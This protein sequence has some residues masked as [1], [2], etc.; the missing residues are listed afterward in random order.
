MVTRA[1]LLWTALPNGR[2]AD[3][4]L[5]LSVHAAPRLTVSGGGETRLDHDAFADVL[6]WPPPGLRFSVTVVGAA[7]QT[8]YSGEDVVEIEP[9]RPAPAEELWQ[10]VFGPSTPVRS[11]AVP[12]LTTVTWHTYPA[13]KLAAW[14]AETYGSLAI[15][16][17]TQ[18][19]TIGALRARFD[20]IDFTGN[21]D[22]RLRWQGARNALD[23]VLSSQGVVD[24][25]APSGP[26]A[27][28]WQLEDFH[29]PAFRDAEDPEKAVEDAFAQGPALPDLDLHQ[30]LAFIGRHPS[31]MRWLG[32]VHDLE[33]P[34]PSGGATGVLLRVRPEWEPSVGTLV[35]HTPWTAC[36]LG[37]GWFTAQPLASETMRHGQL[38][39]DLPDR[40]RALRVDVAGSGLKATRAAGNLTRKV[41][42]PTADTPTT[43]T[44]PSLRTAGFAVV[45]QGRAR[46]LR[47]GAARAVALDGA[48]AAALT[49]GT[50]PT[51]HAEDLV[52]GY[53]VD[54][55]DVASRSWRSLMERQ[56]SF[57]FPDRPDLGE[58]PDTGEGM[59]SSVPTRK[60]DGPDIFAA[61]NLF[62][63]DGWSLVVDRPGMTLALEAPAGADPLQARPVNAAG[64]EHRVTSRFEVVPGT[65]PVLRF[66]HRYEL[67]A[68]TV[69]LAGNSVPMDTLPGI[70]H[71]TSPQHYGRHEPVASPTVLLRTATVPGESVDRVVLRSELAAGPT[72]PSNARHLVVP[73]LAQLQVEEHGALDVVG[74]QGRVPDGS[75]QRHEQIALRD[76][77][78]LSQV[79]EEQL[80]ADGSVL[81]PEAH[82]PVTWSPDPLSRGVALQFVSGRHR[83]TVLSE[84]LVAATKAWPGDWA[85]RL[86]VVDGEGAPSFSPADGGVIVV[87]LRKGDV[88]RIRV[89]SVI[90]DPADVERF[91]LWT[92][93]LGKNPPSATSAGLRTRIAAGLHWM[94]TPDHELVLVHAVRQPLATPEYLGSSPAP[95]R[96]LGATFAI[97]RGTFAFDRR[98]TGRIDVHAAWSEPVDEPAAADDP[99]PVDDTPDVLPPFSRNPDAV[100]FHLD[101]E[102]DDDLDEAEQD[103]IGR[104]EFGDTKHRRVT[105]TAVATTRFLEHFRETYTFVFDGAGSVVELSEVGLVAGTVTLHHAV[106][107]PPG[108]EEG[109]PPTLVP[110]EA[111]DV[112]IDAEEGRITFG[113]GTSGA[114]PTEGTPIEATFNVPPVTRTSSAEGAQ[115][116]V[117]PSSARPPTPGVLYALPT[118]AWERA[119]SGGPAATPAKITSKRGGQGLRIYLERPWWASGEGELL[120][121]V[122][123]PGAGGS[124]DLTDTDALNGYVTE[125]GLDPVFGSANLPR[126]YPG[127]VAFPQRKATGTQLSLAELGPQGDT[128]DVAGHEV[129][130]DTGRNLWY[131]DIEV[132]SGKAYTPMIRL[133]LAR[134]QPDSLQHAHLSSIVLA[135]VVQT[136]PDRL[137]TVAFAS[138][139][140]AGC[141]VTLAGPAPTGTEHGPGPGR[142]QV[143]VE[144]L[145]ASASPTDEL[146]WEPVAAPV[147]MTASQVDGIGTWSRSLTLPT[148][149]RDRLR[150]VVEQFEL[151]AIEA[152]QNK[153][154]PFLPQKA[155][156]VVHTDVIPLHGTGG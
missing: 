137:A 62:V 18:A 147:T 29:A 105:Y 45:E 43:S 104:H 87:P 72:P 76:E 90:G 31:L 100:P 12:D 15:T 129:R 91:G 150:L 28:F 121:V 39:L 80:Q 133:A 11:F 53:R 71:A 153:A 120:G 6:A 84:Q 141:T 83:N 92:W 51:L 116:V 69:D 108:S 52:R 77:A 40:Y 14:L 140:G 19:P 132:A 21:R 154:N 22:S 55:R 134:Y 47:S 16:S 122:T 63:W 152:I 144:R 85:V 138:P 109:I 3:G 64:T 44:I 50:L 42:R 106:P 59:V 34:D 156:R 94:F 135:D 115:V 26:T 66:G 23:D 67:K 114:L 98:S 101:V 54:V 79:E 75:Q 61:E 89:S 36:E 78:L 82:V 8:T 32:L 37:P 148:G 142:A 35:Q 124:G 56:G 118:F 73:K 139:T 149:P 97:L 95:S 103:F 58:V 46:R 65:L 81:Y 25:T 88:A 17:P 123:W 145:P 2:T 113:D 99:E 143:T 151:L 9:A 1:E 48:L 33:I 57:T 93:L 130:F 125:W 27:D 117:I 60:P 131:C 20:A 146:L 13:A 112:T 107:P 96:E 30:A 136:A 70:T 74:E 10:A 102:H 41:E 4:G 49:G 119:E 86:D 38:R 111:E 126:R 24:T 5:R 7:T 127:P 110:I 155:S 68:R 128:V